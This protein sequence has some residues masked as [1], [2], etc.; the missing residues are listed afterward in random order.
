MIK[1]IWFGILV[2]LLAACSSTHALKDRVTNRAY[3]VATL[4][5]RYVTHP[6]KK[7]MYCS[8]NYIVNDSTYVYFVKN[9]SRY[10]VVGEKYQLK[11]D[12]ENPGN[13]YLSLYTPVFLPNE[14]TQKTVGTIKSLFGE[15]C[16]FSYSGPTGSIERIQLV[17]KSVLDR[18]SQIREG[19]QFEVEYDP[20]N[21]ERAI[22][23]FDRPVVN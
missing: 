3:T 22:I 21:P 12:I 11:Y 14:K 8:F 9:P 2:F 18:I 10:W 23:Y 4:N 6:D 13:A 16:L 19:T 15:N 1:A 7:G 20:T 17:N 5:K